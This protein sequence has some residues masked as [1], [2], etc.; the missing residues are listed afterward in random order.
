MLFLTVD[1]DIS[2]T[3]SIVHNTLHK[4][5]SL[6]SLFPNTLLCVELEDIDALVEDIN[7]AAH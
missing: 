1:C 2:R 6:E 7:V 3:M 5:R 4:L